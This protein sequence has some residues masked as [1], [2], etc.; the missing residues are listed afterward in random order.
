MWGHLWTV[1][2]E[3]DET[4]GCGCGLSAV[5]YAAEKGH[6]GSMKTT[7]KPVYVANALDLLPDYVTGFIDGFDSRW[8][9]KYH[10]FLYKEGY[11]DGAD[12]ANAVFCPD[13][14]TSAQNSDPT[15]AISVITTP[16]FDT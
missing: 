7:N 4:I 3:E 1:P 10:D 13:H 11:S 14:N 16:T 15:T 6:P 12:C 8:D 5:C 2:H 9:I